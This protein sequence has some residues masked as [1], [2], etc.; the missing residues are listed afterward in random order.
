MT[1]DAR[2]VKTAADARQIINE[3]DLSHVK[4]GVFDIDGMLRG[5]Y[6]SAKKFL[7]A[8]EKGFG[9]CD[10]V[11]AWDL[12]DQ[13]YD[14]VAYSGWHTGYPD[15]PVRLLPHT[16]RDL[17]MENNGLLF[18]GEFAEQAESLCPRGLLRRVMDKAADMGYQA[19]A[20]F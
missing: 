12:D 7:S 19:Y 6:M 20:G 9:F 13:L 18:L 4:V 1:M 15:A 16:C 3:R 17:P 11:L 8:L 10:V 5:K 2:N 14:N